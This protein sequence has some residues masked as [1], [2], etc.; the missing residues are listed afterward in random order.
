VAPPRSAGPAG[1]P[2]AALPPPRRLH[3][4]SRWRTADH[5]GLPVAAPA[6]AATAT[7]TDAT[8]HATERP[9]V[10][11][12][13]RS[14]VWERTNRVTIAPEDRAGRAG[15][16]ATVLSGG[17]DPVRANVAPRH[18]Q[19]FSEDPATRSQWTSSDI[20]ARLATRSRNPMAMRKSRSSLSLLRTTR[21]VARLPLTSASTNQRTRRRPIRDGQGLLLR[22]R[23][24]PE[25]QPRVRGRSGDDAALSADIAVAPPA[26]RAE[27]GPFV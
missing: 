4:P 5:R 25:Q 1:R 21:R 8:T 27:E 23:R 10:E 7:A 19:A 22:R 20:A 14:S 17:L 13:P 9:P 3:R 6:T 16:Y 11:T 24:R 18:L 12:L 15:R 2:R 26:F